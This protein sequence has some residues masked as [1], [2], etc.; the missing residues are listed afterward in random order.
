MTH[1]YKQAAVRGKESRGLTTG[2]QLLVQ[3]SS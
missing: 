1:I 3:L 2:S